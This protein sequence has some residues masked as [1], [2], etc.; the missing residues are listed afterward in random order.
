MTTYTAP[1]RDMRFVL[2]HIGGLEELSQIDAFAHAEPDMVDGLLA[3]FARLCQEQIAPTNQP[4][5]QEG[6]HL[7]DGVLTTPDAFKGIYEQYVAGG[8]GTIQHP[9][10]H[11]GGSFPLLVANAL[12]EMLQSANLAFSLGPLLT[13]G[14]VHAMHH[15]ASPELQATYLPKMV[16]GE[17]M[18]TMNLTEPHAGSDVGSITSRA[19]PVGDGSYRI[20][21]QKIFIT[22]GEHDLAD[23]II[24]LVLARLPDAPP[25]VKGISLFVVP[26]MLLDEDG[27]ATSEQ[28]DVTAISIEHKLGIHASPTCTMA[29]G[30]NGDGA[31]GWLV[32]D[33]H[34]GMRAMFT[35]MNDARLGVGLQGVSIAERAYQ[36][37]VEYAI[38]RQQGRGP[39]ADPGEQSPIIE[40]PDVRRM[41]LT[42][43]ASIEAARALCYANAAAIDRAAHHPDESVREHNRK[44]ADLYTPLSKAWST[45]LG[46][47]LTSLALQV[48]GGM[49]YVEE[50]GVAQH[51]RD[52]RIAPIYEGTNGI[53]AIDLVGRKLGYD[54]GA[55]VKGVIEDLR[56]SVESLDGEELASIRANLADAVG[57]LSDTTE[58][59]FAHREDMLDVLA[60]AT[61]Y[62]RLFATVVGGEM[63]GRMAAA[64]VAQGTDG[65]DYLAAKVVTA[66][67]FAEQVLPQ[68]TALAAQVRATSR[69]LMALSPS[70]FTA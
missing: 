3:E 26:K 46:V 68:A 19:E 40:H 4:A 25:G 47:E 6:L 12:K 30:E 15:H 55:F 53:Q 35:M 20:F 23:Q 50:T 66:R 57:V 36:Q 8:W 52:A 59:L 63:L 39:G 28:N 45:D 61:P 11:G 37:S 51:L 65:D 17:W 10:E 38:N 7:E 21:G 2:D 5:D 49:G 27:N 41:L 34:D 44:L 42:Q 54:G 24:H 31:L 67:F 9:A 58:W 16:T 29:F 18:G 64:A 14:A 43:K 22:W 56:G 62:L 1:I 60:G 48:H 70:Q 69:D 33:E 32:G 13:T